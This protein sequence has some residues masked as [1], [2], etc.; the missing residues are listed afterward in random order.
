MEGRNEGIWKG[1]MR[2]YGMRGMGERGMR[3]W[4]GRRREE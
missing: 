2:G 1:G 3:V 4:K